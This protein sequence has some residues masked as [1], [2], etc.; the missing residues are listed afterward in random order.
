MTG[1]AKLVRSAVLLRD[2]G[3]CVACGLMVVVEDGNTLRPVQQYSIQHRV[4]RGM[5]GRS[6]LNEPPNLLTM[7]GTGTTGCHGRAE[8]DPEWARHHGYRVDSWDNPQTV[9]VIVRVGPDAEEVYLLDG[10]A[11]IRIFPP[12]GGAR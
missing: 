6:V 3:Q 10:A 4:A 8:S 11:R 9:P 2:G 12:L 1:P 5:G 7:C